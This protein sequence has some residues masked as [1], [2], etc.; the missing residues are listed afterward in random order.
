VNATV[1][2]T[3]TV[4]NARRFTEALGPAA[5]LLLVEGPGHTIES[6][7]DA[8]ALAEIARYLIDR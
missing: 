6:T 8:R 4:A 7:N 1:D 3:Y 2:S 5:R